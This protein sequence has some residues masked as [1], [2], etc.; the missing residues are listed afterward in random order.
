M[1]LT[2]VNMGNG[3]TDWQEAWSGTPQVVVMNPDGLELPKL[4]PPPQNFDSLELVTSNECSGMNNNN[5]VLRNDNGT[6]RLSTTDKVAFAFTGVT[7]AIKSG[8]TINLSV[9]GF[10]QDLAAASS[11]QEAQTAVSTNTG[12]MTSTCPQSTTVPYFQAQCIWN[13]GNP[14]LRMAWQ[15]PPSNYRNPMSQPMLPDH[16]G[17]IVVNIFPTSGVQTGAAQVIGG[18][19]QPCCTQTQIAMDSSY[20]V[21]NPDGSGTQ[22]FY[23]NYIGYY[24]YVTKKWNTGWNSGFYDEALHLSVPIVECN[25][26]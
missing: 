19:S 24:A 13:G 21:P 2:A 11:V 5:F 8:L 1:C 7:I 15:D 26:Q 4:V 10:L 25:C 6:F 23:R 3:G 12:G 16:G 20:F 9:N 17:G 14:F 22:S 18:W